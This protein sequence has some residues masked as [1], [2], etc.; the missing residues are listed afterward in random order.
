MSCPFSRIGLE[1]C[2]PRMRES[3]RKLLSSASWPEM[4]H[5]CRRNWRHHPLRDRARAFVGSNRRHQHSYYK[6]AISSL[7]AELHGGRG[8]VVGNA[9]TQGP[10]MDRRLHD[11]EL[12][13]SELDAIRL[14]TL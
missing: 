13:P 14:P 8:I 12:Q 11:R 6:D 9:S 5:G 1:H 10:A 3:S 7:L 4:G 2:T